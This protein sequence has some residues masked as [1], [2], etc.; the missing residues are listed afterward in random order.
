MKILKVCIIGGG[1]SGLTTAYAL[2]QNFENIKVTIIESGSEK[3]NSNSQKLNN[4]LVNG[5][6]YN[7]IKNGQ[8][9]VLGGN[10][11][12]WGGQMIK[13]LESQLGPRDHINIDKWPIKYNDI[14][15]YSNEVNSFIGIK[16][17]NK[18]KILNQIRKL[19]SLEKNQ[20]QI[21]EWQ[22]YKKRNFY[23][24]TK[25]V[26]QR[27]KNVKILKNT[28]IDKLHIKYQNK[29]KKVSYATT[30]NSQSK[31]F[32]DVFILSAGAIQ[33]SSILLKSIKNSKVGR[34]FT[35]H[36]S[37]KLASIDKNDYK[38]IKYCLNPFFKN[39]QFFYPRIHLPLDMQKKYKLPS[40]FMHLQIIGKKNSALE[41]IK[42]IMRN[43][44]EAN[45]S[46]YEIL[47]LFKIITEIPYLFRLTLAKYFGGKI[48]IPN[49]AELALYIDIEQLPSSS[50]F[51]KKNKSNTVINW[52]HNKNISTTINIFKEY[53]DNGIFKKY[54]IKVK[55]LDEKKFKA[56]LYDTYHPCGGT[57]MSLKSNEAVVNNDLKVKEIEN[58]YVLSTSVF[59]TSASAN[60]TFTLLCLI[61][62]FINYFN[63]KFK[64]YK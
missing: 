5:D 53:L 60:P 48:P 35:D 9:R 29:L 23:N 14:Y 51:I 2:T 38:K 21:S 24:L 10:S 6:K 43:M 16:N 34:N 59:P 45:L 25:E 32:S 1:I 39:K 37:I 18:E 40:A 50:N 31:I 61:F 54:A 46:F 28:T 49:N 30:I 13:N 8:Y 47:N 41:L 62:R 22:P 36:L 12:R 64:K 33:T 15:K 3:I 20:V 17:I 56:N 57:I 27:N 7:G 44:Q 19:L 42:K 58:L 55:W 4:I 26:L 52:K 63:F 11:L